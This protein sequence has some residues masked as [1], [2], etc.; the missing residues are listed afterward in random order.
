[1]GLFWQI[2]VFL[3]VT[4]ALG[5]VIGWLVRGARL[6]G[7]R[8]AAPRS[9]GA[10]AALA[11]ERDRL[12]TE[13]QAARDDSAR[14]EAALTESR[15]LADT[16]AERVRQ[17]EVVEAR[18]KERI[19]R[20]EDELSQSKVAARGPGAAIEG[21]N[22]LAK[23]QSEPAASLLAEG[24]PG[25]PPQGLPAPEGEPDD[26]KQI[27]GIGPGIEKI[28]HELGIYH[29]RQI[30]EFTPANV[31]WVN[32]RLRFKG[33]IEREDWIGQA[34]QLAAAGPVDRASPPAG[35]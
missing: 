3:L 23:A 8:A 13:L 27:S 16:R 32:Q 17:L 14:S 31:A 5:F 28:L 9:S 29:F 22:A 12:R 6:E 24:M 19:A 1:L 25:A 15:S 35:S 2:V 4:A 20:L 26:L 18:S 11:D 30:A 7:A 21:G 34:R 10:E 33:R